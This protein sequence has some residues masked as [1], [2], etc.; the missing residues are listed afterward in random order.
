MIFLDFNMGE[1]SGFETA[2]EIRQWEIDKKIENPALIIGV[3][4]YVSPIE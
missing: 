2:A 1:K 3:S 4:G